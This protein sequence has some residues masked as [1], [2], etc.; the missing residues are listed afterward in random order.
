LARADDARRRS[1]FW[2]IDGAG[3]S[4]PRNLHVEL[5]PSAERSTGESTTRIAPCDT[6][7]P[8]F[9]IA[10]RI[11]K[12][13]WPLRICESPSGHRSSEA[14][15]RAGIVFR[16][17]SIANGY[18][19][20][21]RSSG[22]D[23]APGISREDRLYERLPRASGIREAQQVR[24]LARSH[25]LASTSG[26]RGTTVD[27]RTKGRRYFHDGREC[28]RAPPMDI[29]SVARACMRACATLSRALV[30]DSRCST[31]GVSGSLAIDTHFRPSV[32]GSDIRG[33]GCSEPENNI[34]RTAS[35]RLRD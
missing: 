7:L 4:L 30:I 13:N 5:Y 17:R 15:D 32:L 10:D 29:A 12:N 31:T 6:S 18:R 34:E 1:I 8:A 24:S 16:M 20:I 19:P 14:R 35:R 33:R 2:M 21:P 3:G 9:S 25:S 26:T 11:V 27:S 23:A 22:L 28:T